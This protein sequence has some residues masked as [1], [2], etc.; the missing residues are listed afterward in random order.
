MKNTK[1]NLLGVAVLVV[2]GLATITPSHAQTN[3][4]S[5]NAPAASASLSTTNVLGDLGVSGA[6][7][8]LWNA[9][10]N[11]EILQATNWALA[12]YATYAPSAADKVGAGVLAVYNVPQLTGSL[13]A[14]GAALGADWLGSWSII[15]GNVTIQAPMHPLAHISW[16]SGLPAGITNLTFTPFAVG[17][18]GAPMSGTSGAATLWDVGGQVKF[19][20]WLGGNFGVGASYGEWMNAGKESGH[21][22]HF[23]LSYQ[24]GF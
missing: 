14:V 19:G 5:T 2:T 22:Y 9:V 18:I 1:P 13:G 15:S 20:H 8:N 16:L 24:K 11:S 6:L 23:F 4:V 7:G 10:D 17:G 3:A 12:P 21:R